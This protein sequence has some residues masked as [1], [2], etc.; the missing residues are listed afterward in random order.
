[1]NH[2]NILIIRTSAMGDIVMSSPLAEGLRKKYPQARV[3]WLAEPQVKELLATNPNLDRL[4]VW[5]KTEWK[6]LF[7]SGHLVQLAREV[8]RFGRMLRNEHFT[9]VLDAQGLLRTRLLARLSG[10]PR[11]I[12][13]RSREPGWFLMTEMI[14]K[15]GNP[16][17]MGSEYLHLLETQGCATADLSP[18]I[19]LSPRTREEAASTLGSAGV[20][21]A[22]AVFAPFTTRPQKHWVEQNWIDLARGVREQ[23]GMEVAW[24][25]GPADAEKAAHLAHQGGGISFAGRTSLA[26]S[27]AIIERAALVVGVDTGLVHLGTAFRVPTVALFGATRPYLETPSPCTVVLYHPFP[28]SPCRRSPTCDGR[29]P[30]MA[31]ISAEEALTT[32]TALLRESGTP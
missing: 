1:M 2:P 13:F 27:A 17:R 32:A 21:R 25:G 4:I 16:R 26:V 11:R 10:A 15:G 23:L 6:K 19:Q 24:L 28:C 8:F 7:K 20:T 31:D 12:G 30:C 5:P 29:F 22:F 3:C 9:L 18:R 14:D